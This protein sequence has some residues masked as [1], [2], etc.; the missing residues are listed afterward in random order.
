MVKKTHCLRGHLRSPENLTTKGNCKE[1]E[2][3]RQSMRGSTE[4]SKERGRERSRK[5]RKK[6]IEKIKENSRDWSRGKTGWTPERVSQVLIEQ[7]NA[8]AI[9]KAVFIKVPNADHK[10]VDPPQPRGLL[11][12][13]CNSGLGFLREDPKILREA[14][15]Y[16][17]KYSPEL[18]EV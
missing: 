3:E 10:H 2:R 14:I 11:C 13:P 17:I 5:W 16:L 8:C 7:G 18:R 1:C 12:S 6:N 9:C 15:R 4:E